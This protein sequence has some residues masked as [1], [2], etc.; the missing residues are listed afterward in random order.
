MPGLWR[1]HIW[2]PKLLVRCTFLSKRRG[3]GH[4]PSETFFLEQIVTGQKSLLV[5][6]RLPKATYQ[7]CHALLKT[8]L[9]QP[10]A[11]FIAPD[12]YPQEKSQPHPKANAFDF[13]L[14]SPSST[15][16]PQESPST[17]GAQLPASHTKPALGATVQCPGTMIRSESTTRDDAMSFRTSCSVLPRGLLSMGLCHVLVTLGEQMDSLAPG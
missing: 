4:D 2:P 5:P 8:A 3:P 7:P 6:G 15:K 17:M 9:R 10:G 14:H 11:L 13:S 16:W 1:I 12:E